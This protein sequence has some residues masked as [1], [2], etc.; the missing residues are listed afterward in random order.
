VAR[1][2]NPVLSGITLSKSGKV[3]D[4]L[5]AMSIFVAVV[6]SGSFSA[7]ARKMRTPLATVSRKVADLESHLKA[8]LLV[9][10]TRKL[11]L[12][13]A[14]TAY[15]AACR[16]IL[17]EVGNAE[18]TAAGEYSIPHDELT[19]TAPIVFGRLH[20]LPIVCD[21]LAQFPEI[22]VR[23]VLSDR[24]VPLV[25]DQIDLAVRIGA[26]PDSSLVATRVGAV[27][28]VIC[29]SPKFLET[30]GTPRSERDL[31]NVPFVAFDATAS[32]RSPGLPANVRVRLAVNT[33]EAAVD[34]AI[35][36]VG[37]VRVMS[38]QAVAAVNRGDLKRVLR[39]LEPDPLPVNLVH[40]GQGLLPL[41]LRAF[42][43]FAAPRLRKAL[44]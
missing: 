39:K 42:I 28:Y 13:E 14:G 22:D 15:L 31:E 34:A 41:K 5:D 38:Y 24:N 12:T 10:T 32:G 26:L 35:A 25:E 3:V 8:R 40:T 18:R 21:F 37:L 19:L 33:A 23:L 6:E 30:A 11:S 2:D 7:A 29:G 16:R 36:G 44:S 9:R 17:E 1:R 4:R 20:V 43:D 27:T